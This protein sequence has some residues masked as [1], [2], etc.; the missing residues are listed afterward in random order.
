MTFAFSD[1][2]HH[3]MTIFIDD[4]CIHLE[5]KDHLHW[6]RECLVR[7][8]SSGISLNPAKLYVE[9]KRGVLLG[10]IVSEAGTK[11]DPEKME[12]IHN[13]KPPTDVKGIQRVL[14]HIG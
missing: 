8:H 3:V 10:H 9:V 4:F 13:L 6:V 11:P 14:G 5:E 7:C 2:L 12:V 1:L